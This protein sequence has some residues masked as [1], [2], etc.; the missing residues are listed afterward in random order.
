LPRLQIA[1]PAPRHEPERAAARA[2]RAA[3]AED[4][5]DS[6]VVAAADRYEANCR[7]H[8]AQP[9]PPPA[10]AELVLDRRRQRAERERGEAIDASFEVIPPPVAPPPAS[11]TSLATWEALAAD[12][13][14]TKT[15]RT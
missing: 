4:F 2:A 14:P 10:V 7:A 5:I 15:E 6:D 13:D 11:G 8:R 12:G 9:K 1:A 3:C